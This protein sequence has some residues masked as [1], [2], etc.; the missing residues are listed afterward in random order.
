M[1]I[2]VTTILLYQGALLRSDASHLFGTMLVAPGLAIMV[3]TVLPRLLG[4]WRPVTLAVAGVAIFA[5]SFLLLPQ[6]AVAPESVR[7]WAAAP[8]RDRQRL[9]AE[10][11]PRR[12]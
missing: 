11:R 9:A 8:Y 7:S 2:V 4:A 12:R 1:S 6:S 3:A 5:A 10:P